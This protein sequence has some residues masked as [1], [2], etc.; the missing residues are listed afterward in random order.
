MAVTASG[1]L[2][3]WACCVFGAADQVLAS[4]STGVRCRREGAGPASFG[5]GDG[6]GDGD[7]NDLYPSIAVILLGVNKFEISLLFEGKGGDY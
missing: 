1:R 7:G 3:R 6:G 4:S 2:L 5:G